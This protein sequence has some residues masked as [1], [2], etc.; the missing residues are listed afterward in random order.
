MTD[1]YTRRDVQDAFDL[2]V[3]K[4]RK[5]T[6]P[7]EVGRW[8]LDHSPDGFIVSE[9]ANSAGGESHPFGDRRLTAREFCRQVQFTL[10]ALEIATPQWRSQAAKDAESSSYGGPGYPLY[11]EQSAF[12]HHGRFLA[13][14]DW[15][16]AELML[17]RTLSESLM[18]NEGD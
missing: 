8:I 10:W 6:R 3:K 11:L 2:L 14:H 12:E 16:Q 7:G 9:I 17:T 18:G 5:P 1:R 13:A 4:L 15:P